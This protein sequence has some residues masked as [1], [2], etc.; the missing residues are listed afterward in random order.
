ML[1]AAK[2]ELVA[3]LNELDRRHQFQVIFYNQE[4]Q[5]MPALHG[6]APRM[7]FADEP[8]R[9]LAASFIGGIFADGGT[10]HLQ[11]LQMALALKPDVIFFLTDAEE[12]QMQPEELA[13]VRRLNQGTRINA[14]E[15]GAGEPKAAINFLQRLAAENGG[16]H[17]YV[18]VQRLRR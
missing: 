10:N 5:M 1:A 7:A 11:A 15:F 9:R 8:G 17:A 16:Q 2:R 13:A 14:I 12:P 6:S 4:S 18:D 3:S